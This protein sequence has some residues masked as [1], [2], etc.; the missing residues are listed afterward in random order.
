MTQPRTPIAKLLFLFTVLLTLTG[1]LPAATINVPGDFVTIQ[2]A[3]ADAGTVNGDEIVVTAG[4]YVENIDFLGKAITLRSA[5]GDPTDTI[6]DGGGSGTVVTC[7]SGEDSNTAVRSGMK[8][9]SRKKI[10]C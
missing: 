8:G 5:S 10:V 9:R 1:S 7:D 6:I 3:I 2:G 4:T